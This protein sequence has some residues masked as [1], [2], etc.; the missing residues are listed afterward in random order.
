MSKIARTYLEI[1]VAETTDERNF[2]DAGKFVTPK[3]TQ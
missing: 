1:P 2:S 3:I